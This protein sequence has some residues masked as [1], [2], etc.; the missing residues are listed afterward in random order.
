MAI[1]VGVPI[2]AMGIAFEAGKSFHAAGQIEAIWRTA[3]MVGLGGVICGTVLGAQLFSKRNQTAVVSHEEKPGVRLRGLRPGGP[4]GLILV[5]RREE[6]PMDGHSLGV[7]EL[8]A[9]LGSV[10]LAVVDASR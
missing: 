4:S 3:S 9:A 2:V 5:I 7:I 8:F 6:T 10:G 1:G